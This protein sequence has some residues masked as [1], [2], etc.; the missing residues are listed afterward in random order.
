M[1]HIPIAASG[2]NAAGLTWRQAIVLDLDGATN[3]DSKLTGIGAAELALLKTGAL[4][5]VAE[6]FRFSSINLTPNEKKLEIEARF[7]ELKDS[8]PLTSVILQKQI[9]LE[10]IGYE[11]NLP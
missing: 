7:T 6:T 5:E 3:I 10:W 11:N 8:D 9:I 2:T 1:F 4:F